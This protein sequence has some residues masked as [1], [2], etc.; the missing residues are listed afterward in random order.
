MY[1]VVLAGGS[2]SLPLFSYISHRFQ[3]VCCTERSHAD[4][5]TRYQ[6][7]GHIAN[8]PTCINAFGLHCIHVHCKSKPLWLRHVCHYRLDNIRYV[9]TRYMNFITSWF[10]TWPTS[11]WTLQFYHLYCLSLIVWLLIARC[12][13]FIYHMLC[14]DTRSRCEAKLKVV[15]S[16][17]AWNQTEGWIQS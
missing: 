10:K 6:C 7:H 13:L 4:V 12:A 5:L 14:R 16:S 8:V 17:L 3:L 9:Y 2:K 11:R 1:V 15:T